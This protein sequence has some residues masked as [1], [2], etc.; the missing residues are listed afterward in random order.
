MPSF[1]LKNKAF[2]CE[3]IYDK[4]YVQMKIR[5]KP[6]DTTLGDQSVGVIL[7]EN[8][9]S[10]KEL[11]SLLFRKSDETSD[12]WRERTVVIKISRRGALGSVKAIKFVF[13]DYHNNVYDGGATVEISDVTF[14]AG[15]Y[16]N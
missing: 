5:I 1:T 11:R 4:Y 9:S 13:S 14:I 10:S 6:N 2:G 3:D 15:K 8:S 12:G 16:Y 7:E